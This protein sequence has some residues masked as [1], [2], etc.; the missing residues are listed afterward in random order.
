MG[1]LRL[2][3]AIFIFLHRPNLPVPCRAAIGAALFHTVENPRRFGAFTGD[4]PRMCF[5]NLRRAIG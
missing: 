1:G 5:I 2:S 4:R 3:L